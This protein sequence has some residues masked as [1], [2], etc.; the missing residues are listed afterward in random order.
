MWAVWVAGVLVLNG[1]FGAIMWEAL[2]VDYEDR[3]LYKWYQSA[4]YNFLKLLVL[5]LWPIGLWILNTSKDEHPSL[6]VDGYPNVRG[7]CSNC[8]KPTLFN[9]CGMELICSE[10]SHNMFAFHPG[11][12]DMTKEQLAEWLKN[13]SDRRKV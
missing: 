12:V 4:P 7:W 2:N 13:K 8:E 11:K 6:T 5:E 3:K 9:I 10:C 1:I